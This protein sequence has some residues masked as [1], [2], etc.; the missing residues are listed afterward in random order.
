MYD[1]ICHL[2]IASRTNTRSKNVTQLLASKSIDILLKGVQ[3]GLFGEHL[4]F[5]RVS[6]QYTFHVTNNSGVPL[7]P[8][9]SLFAAAF[10]VC[11]L[12]IL[13]HKSLSASFQNAV[14]KTFSLLIHKHLLLHHKQ[15][16]LE[17][18]IC[19]LLLW[20]LRENVNTE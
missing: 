3:Q 19:F 12:K 5:W 17:G 10:F 14:I 16:V 6:I 7:L 13:F 2:D 11:A 1:K 20:Y 4:V 9:F 8:R 18:D 15:V